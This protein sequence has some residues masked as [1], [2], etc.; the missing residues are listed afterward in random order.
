MVG[1][2]LKW[3]ELFKEAVWNERSWSP[4]AVQYLTVKGNEQKHVKET[5]KKKSREIPRNTMSLKLIENCGYK[6]EN[7]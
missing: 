2:D 7:K 3:R 1:K 6:Q 5:K 4:K